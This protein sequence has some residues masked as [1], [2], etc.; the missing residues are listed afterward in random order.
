MLDQQKE[1][2]LVCRAWFLNGVKSRKGTTVQCG[3]SHKDAMPQKL[4]TLRDPH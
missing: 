3:Q 4:P 2:M 1:E